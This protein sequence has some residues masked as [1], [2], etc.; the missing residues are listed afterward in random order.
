[1]RGHNNNASNIE[2][3][4]SSDGP[5]TLTR[6]RKEKKDNCEAFCVTRKRKKRKTNKKLFALHT[7]AKTHK[8]QERLLQS[9]AYANAK[10]MAIEKLFTLHTNTRVAIAR[11][12]AIHAK[13]QTS[14]KAI[15]KLFAY[16]NAKMGIGEFS[17]LHANVI[18]LI[19]G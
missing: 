19:I 5:E 7:N 9:F 11:L 1:M 10:G 12:F 16:E 18:L 2:N 6:K 4:L 17:T 14:R 3:R 15:A 13:A 8:Q